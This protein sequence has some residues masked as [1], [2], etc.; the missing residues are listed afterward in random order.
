LRPGVPDHLSRKRPPRGEEPLLT[1]YQA[2]RAIT[3]LGSFGYESNMFHSCHVTAGNLACPKPIA[4]WL[5]LGPL[6]HVCTEYR[7]SRGSKLLSYIFY[8]P[9]SRSRA[10]HLV[11]VSVGFLFFSHTDFAPGNTFRLVSEAACHLAG[12]IAWAE[13]K[14]CP[15]GLAPPWREYLFCTTANHDSKTFGAPQD[16]A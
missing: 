4:L 6:L 2:S 15:L 7:V 13:M 10:R 16:L 8:F 14:M 11:S 12:V 9:I 3:R 5:C 1:V